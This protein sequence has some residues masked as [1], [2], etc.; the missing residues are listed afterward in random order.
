[1]KR[2]I[3]FG[4]IGCFV[5]GLALIVTERTF[6]KSDV[7]KVCKANDLHKDLVFVNDMVAPDLSV[8]IENKLF[9]RLEDVAV[10]EF[11]ADILPVANSP[12]FAGI[13]GV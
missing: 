8:K 3:S 4:L 6:V 12:P 5:I 2:F 10:S 9:V 11:K 13:T 1:M 7:E